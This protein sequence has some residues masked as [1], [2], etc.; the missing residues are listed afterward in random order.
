M[1]DDRPPDAAQQRPAHEQQPDPAP[2]TARELPAVPGGLPLI[3]HA[4]PFLRDP[5]AFLLRHHA[6][7]GEALTF[8]V[9]G[10]DVASLCSPQLNAAVLG[11]DDTELTRRYTHT[12]LDLVFGEGHVLDDPPEL[13]AWHRRVARPVLRR[14]AMAQHVTTMYELAERYTA[15]WGPRGEADLVTT[16]REVTALFATHCL[17]GPRFGR[18]MGSS[19]PALLDR[20]E[21]AFHVSLAISPRAP[22]PVHRRRDRARDTLT[23]AIKDIAPT[24]RPA[25]VDRGLF[26]TITGTPRP[27]GTAPD[28]NTAAAIVISLLFGGYATTAAQAAWTGAL[29][30]QHPR[31]V[32]VVRAEQDALFAQEAAPTLHLLTR[33]ER[34]GH[35]LMEAERL[36]PSARGILRTAARDVTIG[37]HLVPRGHMVIVSPAASHRLPQV[38]RDPDRYDLDRYAG[39]A[40]HRGTPS[41]L[42]GFGG[43]HHPCLG[44]SFAQQ[45]MKVLWSVL[46]RDFDLELADPDVRPVRL[47]LI[48]PPRRPCLLRYRRRK[49]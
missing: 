49:P 33:M 25:G 30:L 20:L 26:E 40:E 27:D 9:L 3:G 42:I 34:L 38:F 23:R 32:P 41:P 13:I 48:T 31:W 2:D 14:E 22:L 37:G 1:N 7:L 29:L 47:G 17:V 8:S 10:I 21:S 39:R 18:A 5:G 4:V 36:R 11:H 12:R 16:A 35:C 15:R 6:A 43:G 45:A 44:M 28:P 19:L 24:D 46:L